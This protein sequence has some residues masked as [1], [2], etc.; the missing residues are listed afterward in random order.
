MLRSL[1]VTTLFAISLTSAAL[2][3]ST[4]AM[5]LNT[6]IAQAAEKI[7]APLLDSRSSS[8]VYKKWFADCVA[9]SNA[10]ITASLAASRPT[11]T[12]LLH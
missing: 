10:K 3:D 1:T 6:R 12:A 5:D 7:C 11:S 2:A 9:G 4:P 8:L